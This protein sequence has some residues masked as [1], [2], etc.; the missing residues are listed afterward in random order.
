[1]TVM[2][3][4]KDERLLFELPGADLLAPYARK[5]QEALDHIEAFTTGPAGPAGNVAATLAV[6]EAA[7]VA[8][9]VMLAAFA[10][11]EPFRWTD[12]DFSAT[13]AAELG[14]SLVESDHQPLTAGAWI[15]ARDAINARRF[16]ARFDGWTDDAPAL[17]AAVDAAHAQGAV[18]ILPG[19]TALLGA[20]LDLRGRNVRIRG[21]GMERTTLKAAA[22]M[23][24]LIDARGAED[25]IFSSFHLSDLCIDGAD[26]AAVG[27]A[28]RYRHQSTLRDMLVM[29][30]GTGVWER[31]TWLSRRF[32]VR[33]Q[34]NDV[35]WHLAGS[36]H[37]SKWD[38]CSFN[39]ATT[40]S[41]LIRSDGT[42]NDGNIALGFSGCDV[43]F[44]EAGG[45]AEVGLDVGERCE[46][47]F[48][49]C[50]IGEQIEGDIIRNRGKTTVRGGAVFFGYKPTSVL[51]RPL[52][53]EVVIDG[54]EI[55]GQEF[56]SKANLADLQ[57]AEIEAG[58]G[59]WQLRN[60]RVNIPVGGDVT[61]PGDTLG[62]TSRRTLAPRFGKSY[63]AAGDN[64]TFTDALS[65]SLTPPG[66][67]G[68]RRITCTGVTG[69][70]PVLALQAALADRDWADGEPLYLVMVYR[71]SR[72]VQV[73]LS[74]GPF[75]VTPTL[76]V[77]VAPARETFCTYVAVEAP[78]PAG[79]VTLVEVVLP[80]AAA[81]DW[82][83]LHRITLSSDG[84]IGNLALA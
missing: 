8:N 53:G 29:N 57:P 23:D 37:S 84:S 49:A 12:G 68:A 27:L 31:D 79:A 15:V 69:E 19:G 18:L 73:K 24:A 44:G 2:F 5:A 38:A 46:A 40:S 6:L 72:P 64:V 48:E 36:N 78:A 60:C 13:P 71:A 66:P 43:E 14:V 59:R 65:A 83:D 26:L 61:I 70:N 50:Y 41:L 55:N 10:G 16:G 1:M 67:K 82:L 3:D 4:L 17:Q 33:A 47:S 76:D 74:A 22:A 45:F 51:I 30:C 28:V 25:V 39:G 56:A 34:S 54:A 21:G 9:R 58:G 62:S 81:G 32:N 7:P 11:G 77:G 75:G 63:T 20:P 80:N 35:C 52:G 42:E